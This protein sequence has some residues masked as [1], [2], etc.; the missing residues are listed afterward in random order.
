MALL[1]VLALV[2]AVA[3]ILVAFRAPA[4]NAP[5]GPWWGWLSRT[6]QIASLLI[7]ANALLRM[8]LRPFAKEVAARGHGAGATLRITFARLLRPNLT[9]ELQASQ[10]ERIASVV[11][12]GIPSHSLAAVLRPTSGGQPEHARSVRFGSTHAVVPIARWR[13]DRLTRSLNRTLGIGEFAPPS[14]A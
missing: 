6:L 1:G 8:S 2:T 14:S 10:I 3:S 11:A 4:P 13:A 5:F 9:T 12:E 7:G